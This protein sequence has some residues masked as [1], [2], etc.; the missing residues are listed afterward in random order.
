MTNRRKIK[1]KKVDRARSVPPPPS[2]PILP[3]PRQPQGPVRKLYTTLKPGDPRLVVPQVVRRSPRSAPG[4]PDAEDAREWL[5]ENLA[6]TERRSPEHF[7]Y[8]AEVCE[9]I[10]DLPDDDPDLAVAVELLTT[11]DRIPGCC[12]DVMIDGDPEDTVDAIMEVLDDD[13][14]RV[15]QRDP[16]C[17]IVIVDPVTTLRDP[18]ILRTLARVRDACIGVYGSIV[19]PGR[20][21][22]G[23]SVWLVHAADV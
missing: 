6:Y 20:V 22:V 15:D 9:Y 21:A 2:T 3:P 16:R 13:E 1:N 19:R 17:V 4:A 5:T 14:M 10:R 8:Y 7:E 23:D 11:Y 12:H 18:S